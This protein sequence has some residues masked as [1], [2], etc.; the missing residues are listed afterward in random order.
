[1]PLDD[2]TRMGARWRAANS[3]SHSLIACSSPHAFTRM[4]TAVAG[5]V[6]GFV[7]ARID[8]RLA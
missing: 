6:E 4:D 5:K 8:A 7:D 2:R 1:M 3:S